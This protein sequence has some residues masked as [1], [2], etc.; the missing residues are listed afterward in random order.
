[1]Q[2][3]KRRMTSA[4]EGEAS[5]P[6]LGRARDDF[7]VSPQASL[8]LMPEASAP[9]AP[10][11]GVK[12]GSKWQSILG[13]TLNP[14]VATEFDEQADMSTSSLGQEVSEGPW[15]VTASRAASPG[16]FGPPRVPRGSVGGSRGRAKPAADPSLLAGPAAAAANQEGQAPGPSPFRS[17]LRS[18]FEPGPLS[19][20]TVPEGGYSNE[21]LQSALRRMSPAD[22]ASQLAGRRPS[23]M[24]TVLQSNPELLNALLAP[25]LKAHLDGPSKRMGVIG[26]AVEFIVQVDQDPMRGGKEVEAGDLK[27]YVRSGP[28]R[29]K[30]FKVDVVK[31]GEGR[32]SMSWGTHVSGVYV[33]ALT[34]QNSGVDGSPVEVQVEMPV[35]TAEN[36]T[37]RGIRAVHAGAKST[38]H[39]IARDQA[40]NQ[41]SKGGDDFHVSIKGPGRLAYAIVRDESNGSYSVSF[42]A[43]TAG[44]YK[45]HITF[46]NK[47]GEKP[48]LGSP[49]NFEVMPGPCAPNRVKIAEDPGAAG[50]PSLLLFERAR[51]NAIAAAAVTGMQLALGSPRGYGENE[52]EFGSFGEQ[53][54][55]DMHPVIPL[56]STAGVPGRF[57]I[58]GADAFGNALRQ[59][60][61]RFEAFL[62]PWTEDT[63]EYVEIRDLTPPASP[64]QDDI[65]PEWRTGASPRHR[66]RSSVTRRS[67]QHV[68]LLGQANR[69]AVPSPRRSTAIAARRSFATNPA[70]PPV[71]AHLDVRTPNL[72]VPRR[73]RMD[74]LTL[75]QT[76]PRRRSTMMQ[77]PEGPTLLGAFSSAVGARANRR[78]SLAYSPSRG[79]RRRSVMMADQQSSRGGHEPEEPEGIRRAIVHLPE[80]VPRV[81]VEVANRGD[82]FSYGVYQLERAGDYALVISTNGNVLSHLGMVHVRASGAV[83][84]TSHIVD[85][86]LLP[87]VVIAG[88]FH[89]CIVQCCDKFG[90]PLKKGGD[91]ITV[92]IKPQ[93]KRRELRRRAQG[94]VDLVLVV[95]YFSFLSPYRLL[96]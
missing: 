36:C 59:G 95:S 88:E 67:S 80:H 19:G 16:H 63:R 72:R 83:P 52:G 11:L 12:R 85:R 10:G 75:P 70:Q 41:R 17:R 4:L 47:V 68:P 82:G 50:E 61:D 29:S 21:Q 3:G 20:I 48:L 14:A 84:E 76:S 53:G 9:A 49:F 34:C 56:D 25:K 8:T 55:L 31:I 15:S 92:E 2:G 65:P 46:I 74:D 1:M 89:E 81:P 44:N 32:F 60:G 51:E 58:T 38:F 43:D 26:S 54:G 73:S 22:A 71:P 86:S 33:L 18:N 7:S 96:L 87:S 93:Q 13:A 24:A 78:V 35:T 28:A 62:I 27:L 57:W 30:D 23:F 94:C 66:R 37:V 42:R 69:A 5:V 40:G 6:V 77:P 64:G 79:N 45:A 90:N 39:V 91:E